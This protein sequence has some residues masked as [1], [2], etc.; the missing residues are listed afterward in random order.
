MPG[1]AAQRRIWES[2]VGGG[3]GDGVDDGLKAGGVGKGG[4]EGDVDGEG[5]M[6][7]EESGMKR[8]EYV[9]SGG[10]KREEY[11]MG[12]VISGREGGGYE[13]KGKG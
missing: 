8:E 5:G 9:M 6:K 10:L 12:E 3:D 7:G 4:E 11:E 2:E 1:A 13:G